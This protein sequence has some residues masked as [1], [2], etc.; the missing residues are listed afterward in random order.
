MADVNRGNRPLSPHLQIY[1]LGI[2]GNLSIL[3]RLTG[4]ALTFGAL[5]GVFWF[6][7]AATGPQYFAIVDAIMTSWI[8][9]LILLGSLWALAY[10][11]LN[12][13][14]HLVW[15]LGYGFDLDDVRKS[16]IAVVAGSVVLTLL[17]AAIA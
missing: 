9:N 4:V 7:A 17:V 16:G 2:T 12:G 14:R 5:L 10:H 13:I 15:D 3:H 6:L 11:T 8:G 1:K